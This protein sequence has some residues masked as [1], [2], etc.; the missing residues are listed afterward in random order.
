MF[1]YL[2]AQRLIASANMS[3][4]DDDRLNSE[5]YP[6]RF[7][8]LYEEARGLLEQGKKTSVPM[9]FGF[10]KNGPLPPFEEFRPRLTP[11]PGGFAERGVASWVRGYEMASNVVTL[12]KPPKGSPAA[13]YSIALARPTALGWWLLLS[14]GLSL[15]Y[16]RTLGVWTVLAI[17]YLCGVFLVS[18]VNARYFAPAWLVFLPVLFVPLDLLFRSIARARA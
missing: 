16:W 1:L 12:P 11:A 17:G 3:G 4:F 7:A 5:Y 18:L 15:F 2:G 14:L 13:A 10:P 8:K 9:A 6:R